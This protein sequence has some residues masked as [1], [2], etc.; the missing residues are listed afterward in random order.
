MLDEVKKWYERKENWYIG[1]SII[2]ILVAFSMPI[3][4]YLRYREYRDYSGLAGLGPVGDFIGGSTMAFLNLASFLMVVA[5][6]IMQKE[7]LSL[8]R[9]EVK[10]TREEYQKT[11]ITM[12]KQQV[13]NT[14]F[15]MVKLHNDIVNAIELKEKKGRI[16]LKEIYEWLG[17]SIESNST[18][19]ELVQSQYNSFYESF[20]HIL[21][22]YFRNL[23]RIVKFIDESELTEIEKKN[24]LGILRAQLSKE[25]LLLIFYNALSI[26]G[27]NFK[28]LIIE[29]NFFDDHLDLNSLVTPEHYK[30]L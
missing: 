8:Q 4:I 24:Y 28:E 2:F 11:N 20:E 19:L 23:Y 7:E 3:L 22:H 10:R 30:L 21:G 17:Y 1:I 25:E 27:E 29:Y 16:C 14:F 18:E 13:D 12:K 15:N 5:A 26:R 9:E 6:I